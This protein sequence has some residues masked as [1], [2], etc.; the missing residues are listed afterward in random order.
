M[1]QLALTLVS[2]VEAMAQRGRQRIVDGIVDLWGK[3]CPDGPRR[4]L[5]P[6]QLRAYRL[7]LRAAKREGAR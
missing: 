1:K 5:T 4:K 6:A 7:A 2:P 3:H